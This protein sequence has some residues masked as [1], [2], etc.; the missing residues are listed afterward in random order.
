MVRR[1]HFGLVGAL[2]VIALAFAWMLPAKADSVGLYLDSDCTGGG[3][4]YYTSSPATV[5][6]YNL[7]TNYDCIRLA[8][9]SWLVSG[10]WQ[11]WGWEQDDENIHYDNYGASGSRGKHQL[12]EGFYGTGVGN[13]C[14]AGA[15][16]CGTW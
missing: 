9:R 7:Y 14:Y 5:G 12:I 6:T 4:S 8:R 13:T 2:C 1:W 16:N 11:D 3:Y 15:G 10:S